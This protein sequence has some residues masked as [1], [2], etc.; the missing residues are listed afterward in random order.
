MVQQRRGR[1]VKVKQT[2]FNK[3]FSKHYVDLTKTN[4]AFM[5]IVREVL[6]QLHSAI[7][8]TDRYGVDKIKETI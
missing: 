4:A 5:K 6:I 3:R 2:S 1:S 7:T 8:I